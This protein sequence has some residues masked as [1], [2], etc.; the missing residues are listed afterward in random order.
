MLVEMIVE[1]FGMY[2][3]YMIIVEMKKQPPD[4]R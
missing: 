4:Q 3:L 2:L 1:I